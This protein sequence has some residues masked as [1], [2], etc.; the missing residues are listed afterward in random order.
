MKYWYDHDKCCIYE[1]KFNQD[2]GCWYNAYEECFYT[3]STAH[4]TLEACE[5]ERQQYIKGSIAFWKSQQ[6]KPG[7]VHTF[8]E[9][10]DDW[11][12]EDD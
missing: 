12:N 4:D 1:L 2:T 9:I 11:V 6:R 3:A 8:E 7:Y 10:G 5:K